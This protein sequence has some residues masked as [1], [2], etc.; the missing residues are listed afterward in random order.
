MIGSDNVPRGGARPVTILCVDDE[1]NIL[2]SLR[3]LFRPQGYEV[4]T[5]V[6]G[7][8]GLKVLESQPVDVI[9]SDM[10]MPEMDGAQ[11]LER[12]RARWPDTLR[13]LLTGY[14]DIQLIIG[15]INRGEIYRYITKPWDDNDILLV[16]RH[17]LERKALEQEKQRLE[18]LTQLQNE[19][20]RNLNAGLENKV[21]LRTAALNRL[22]DELLAS[23]EKLKTSFLT[24]I[25]VFSNLIEMRG[26]NL[27]GHS[28]RVA[29]LARRIAVRVGLD[30][31]ETQEVFIAGLLH[32]IG[33][34]GFSDALLTMPV[35][36]MNG[37][38]L[39]QYRKYPVRGE[40]LLMPL[41]DLRDAAKIVRSHQE[42]FDGEG[43]PDR[44]SGFDIP[45]GARV[46]ALAS[47]Y[48][49][50]Q[51]GTLSQRFLRPDQAA[52]LVIES[53][54]KRYDAAVVAAFLDVI[55]GVTGV[56]S[57][58]GKPLSVPE[59]QPGMV[60]A[61]DIVTKDGSL[62]LSADHVLSERLIRQIADFEQSSGEVF[63]VYIVEERP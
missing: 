52:A 39:G 61:R 48:D 49:N 63:T 62:L 31:R 25:K 43:F 37:D 47:D 9:I 23:N 3:R 58:Q 14:A 32:N 18:T 5:E 56:D 34:I 42:R 29:D 54:G 26:A 16:V 12:V 53:R 28:R 33:K 20:L 22:H 17:A 46:L 55:N 36:M 7:H 4:L 21:A 11:F 24:S 35:S 50:L 15:A 10:R 41:E 59:L 13:L 6:S 38:N 57:M 8:A 1:P 51:I 19:E 45:I 30:A 27:A 2:S 40:Q 60:T 44:L